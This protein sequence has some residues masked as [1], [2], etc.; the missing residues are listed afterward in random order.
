MRVESDDINLGEDDVAEE[1]LGSLYWQQFSRARRRSLV[2]LGHSQF[3]DKSPE[4]KVETENT[5]VSRSLSSLAP[6]VI[7]N[8]A[9]TIS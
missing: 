3:S 4:G 9:S 1:G 7:P 2:V 8:T 5:H 6:A